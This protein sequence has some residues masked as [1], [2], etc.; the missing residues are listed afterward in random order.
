MVSLFPPAGVEIAKIK[1]RDVPTIL[2]VFPI[3]RKTANF[4]IRLRV[5][6]FS[7]I[8]VSL[9][10]RTVSIG[11]TMLRMKEHTPYMIM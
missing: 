6:L 7:E 4:V 10:Y 9:M 3:R 8:V 2:S 1:G 11:N 5:S